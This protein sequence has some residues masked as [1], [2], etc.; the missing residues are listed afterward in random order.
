MTAP[1]RSAL[2]SAAGYLCCA[3][4]DLRRAGY[5]ALADEIGLLI[6]YVSDE[7]A[8]PMD[9]WPRPWPGAAL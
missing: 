4:E 3:E 2:L 6:A 5:D 1:S 7:V 8:D 9:D